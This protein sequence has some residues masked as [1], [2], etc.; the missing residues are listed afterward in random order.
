MAKKRT[1]GTPLKTTIQ[2]IEDELPLFETAAELEGAPSVVDWLLMI[3]RK[4]ARLIAAK[5]AVRVTEVL[6]PPPEQTRIEPK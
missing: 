4:R 6:V 2:F 3:G 5:G 1:K